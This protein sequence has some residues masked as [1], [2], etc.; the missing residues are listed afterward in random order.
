M[1]DVLERIDGELARW[2]ES[3]PVFFVATAPSG[4]EGLVNCS[5]KGGDSL[6]VLDPHSVAYLDLTGSGVETIAH[7][8]ENGRIVIMLCAFDGP[9]RIV[10]I[11]G[12]GE[13]VV[14]GAADF[15]DLA[16]KFPAAPGTRSVIRVRAQ[17]I[18]SSCGYAVPLMDLREPRKALDLWAEKRGPDGLREYQRTHNASSLDGLTGVDWLGK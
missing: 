16:A 12:R 14:P 6:R 15:D 17:R 13:V 9:P 18:S 1:A 8:R 5:P 4:N 11:H 7:V 3:Q 2:M 10:R